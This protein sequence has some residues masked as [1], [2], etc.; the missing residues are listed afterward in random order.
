MSSSPIWPLLPLEKTTTHAS[1]LERGGLEMTLDIAYEVSA[2]Q[3]AQPPGAVRFLLCSLCGSLLPHGL[4]SH[5]CFGKC[6]AQKGTGWWEPEVETI[7]CNKTLLLYLFSW[8][9]TRIPTNIIKCIFFL[10][11]VVQWIER[12]PANQRSP[13]G[14]SVRAQAWVVGQVPSS[15]CVGGNHTLMIL[16]FSFSLPFPLSKNKYI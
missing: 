11:G 1:S 6:Q 4:S 14:F 10:A 16:S 2:R 13:V 8:I 12:G 9:S 7:F 5:L 3:S 15:G